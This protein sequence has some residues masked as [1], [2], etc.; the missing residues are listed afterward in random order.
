M[1]VQLSGAGVLNEHSGGCV[2]TARAHIYARKSPAV[3]RDG[4]G[5]IDFER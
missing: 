3:A 5:L 1:M 2:E 4:E